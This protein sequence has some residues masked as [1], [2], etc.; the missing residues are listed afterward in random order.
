M[1]NMVNE[2]C[3]FIIQLD[4]SCVYRHQNALMLFKEFSNIFTDNAFAVLGVIK[5]VINK[6]I[7]TDKTLVLSTEL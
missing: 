5:M 6:A 7:F 2:R 3:D 4:D 1:F